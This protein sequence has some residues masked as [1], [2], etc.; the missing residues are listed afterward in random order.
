[1]STP[2]TVATLRR[3]LD[4][5]LD[6]AIES[7]SPEQALAVGNLRAELEKPSGWRPID[8]APKD[9]TTLILFFPVFGTAPTQGFGR[10]DPQRHNTRPRP[11]WTGDLEAVMGVSRYRKYPPSHWRLPPDY[12]EV[13]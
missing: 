2:S 10:W 7:R 5:L 6:I 13:P 3:A 9:G 11:L 12:P 4:A 8:T 1:V